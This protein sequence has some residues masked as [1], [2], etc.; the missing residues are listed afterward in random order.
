MIPT[1]AAFFVGFFLCLLIVSIKNS[2]KQYQLGKVIDKRKEGFT[3]N[4]SSPS[5]YIT[6]RHDKGVKEVDVDYSAYEAFKVGDNI[7]INR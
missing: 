1:V 2:L 4:V 6:I 3:S 7:V 5:Y